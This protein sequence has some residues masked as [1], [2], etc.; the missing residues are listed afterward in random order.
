MLFAKRESKVDDNP[1]QLW[2]GCALRRERHLHQD[3]DRASEIRTSG[4]ISNTLEPQRIAI[5]LRAGRAT[6]QV[7]AMKIVTS[8]EGIRTQLQRRMDLSTWIPGYHLGCVAP[9]PYRIVDDGV[10]NWIVNV[11]ATSKPGCEGFVLQ[12]LST[13]RRDYDLPTQSLGEAVAELL[14]SRK[15][16]L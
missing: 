8:V 7:H 12:V 13:V 11:S 5:G 14:F 1:S 10:A 16:R 6:G 2:G 9:S 4:Q 15:P 3:L